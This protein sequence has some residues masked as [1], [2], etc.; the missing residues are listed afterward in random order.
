MSGTM[1]WF[2]FFPSDWLAGTRGLS[3]NA[4]AAYITILALI[5]EHDG[6]VKADPAWLARYCSMSRRQF[7]TALDLLVAKGKIQVLE[8][9]GLWNAR[10]AVEI[11]KRNKASA[12]QRENV[13]RRWDKKGNKNSG[14]KIPAH[15]FGKASVIPIGYQ[16]ES[17]SES[18][19]K[20]EAKAIAFAKKKRLAYRLSENWKIP[21][22]WVA[23]AVAEGMPHATA[24]AEAERMKNW[25]LSNKNG[26]K[27]DW[28][29][30]WKN[31]FRK[32][33]AHAST[34]PPRSPTLDSEAEEAQRFLDTV[35]AKGQGNG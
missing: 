15:I 1:P 7:A 22:A 35:I 32:E 26:A 24:M 33:L 19:R 20:K 6:P 9:G 8:N 21:P 3:A 11:R 30:A 29:A 17:D 12:Q 23:E 4:T 18:D 10:A 27:L 28:H 5:Y 25:S 2:P 13:N 34:G 16:P 14:K 31:W